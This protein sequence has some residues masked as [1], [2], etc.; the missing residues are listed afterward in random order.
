MPPLNPFSWSDHFQ[1][2]SDPSPSCRE[3]SHKFSVA[4]RKSLN[5]Y[6]GFRGRAWSGPHLPLQSHPAASPLVLRAP[7][8]LTFF[9]FFKP[10]ELPL[11]SGLLHKLLPLPGM[12]AHPSR[13]GWSLIT[14]SGRP[15]PAS[16]TRS[17]LSMEP[18]ISPPWHS[19]EA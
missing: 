2:N 8:T 7:D 12:P 11:T 10:S 16:L 3:H 1:I 4:L 17:N 9:R 18:C 5:A 15:C 6:R 13:L 14:S 19:S